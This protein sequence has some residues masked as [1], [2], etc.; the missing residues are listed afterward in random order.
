MLPL[1]AR[2][3]DFAKIRELEKSLPPRH[4]RGS[5]LRA[6]QQIRYRLSKLTSIYGDGILVLIPSS[7]RFGGC[8][9]VLAN[10]DEAAYRFFL[11]HIA[12]NHD[13]FLSKVCPFL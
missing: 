10:M 3:I 6:L 5:N 12:D 13:Q 11:Q 7:G 9:N 4:G 2:G 1:T 8:L